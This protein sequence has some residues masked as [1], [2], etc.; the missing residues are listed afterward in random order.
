MEIISEKKKY[1]NSKIFSPKSYIKKHVYHVVPCN[2]KRKK[3]VSSDDFIIPK[4]NEYYLLLE[5]NYNVSQLKTICKKYGL[6]ISGNK[7]EKIH[8][9]YNYLKFSFYTTKIQKIYRGYLIRKYIIYKGY[10]L[11]KLGINN[12]TDFLTFER[13]DKISFDQLFCYKDKDNFIYGFDVRSIYNMLLLDKTAKN[14]YNRKDIKI[15]TIENV[16]NMIKLGKI[17]KR[18]MVIEMSNDIEELPLDKQLDLAAIN[19]FQTMDDLGFI[20]DANWF[21]NLSKIKMLQL[22]RELIDIWSYRL[23]IP[24]IMKR[25]IIPPHGNPFIEFDLDRLRHYSF[26]KLKKVSLR[27]IKNLVSSGIDKDARYLGTH[28]VLGA[29]T[30]VNYEAASALPWLYESFRYNN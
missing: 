16:T 6:K 21:I 22:I 9:I 8:R 27:M 23:K 19:I 15:E 18:G 17:L 2:K 25:K 30:L 28:Y 13:T 7:N 1:K 12:P 29:L 5:L 3:K 10:K 26:T 24:T 14:P 4:Y 20:T 11:K